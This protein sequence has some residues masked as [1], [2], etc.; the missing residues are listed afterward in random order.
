M[1]AQRGSRT[2]EFVPESRI[3]FVGR[4]LEGEHRDCLEDGVNFCRECWM[5]L[6]RGAETKLK[7][8]DDA[9]A[10]F[11]FTDDRKPL[12]RQP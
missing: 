7:G 8:N 11:V 6:L 4:L 2:F 1:S 5:A 3:R 12:G 9:C 10:D